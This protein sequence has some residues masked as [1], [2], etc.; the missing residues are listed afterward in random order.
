MIILVD[1]GHGYN[2]NGKASPILD[3]EIPN[4]FVYK[5]RFR[6]ALYNRVIAKEL[7]T[8]LKDND[9]DARLVVP[10]DIDVSLSERVRRINTI[11]NR[12]GASNVILISIHS[13]AAGNGTSFLNANGWEAYTTRGVTKSDKLAE[14]LYKRAEKNFPNRKIRTDCTDGDLDKEADF[15]IIKKSKCP[16]VLTEN[17][18]YDNKEDLKYMTSDLGH[19]EVVR[20]HIYGIIDYSEYLKKKK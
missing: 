6:E 10:E 11:C 12:E 4:Q 5:N 8:K 19:F 14:Y 16:A 18:F 15:Y 17:F 20:T 7:V 9:Y 2:T 1:N 3:F 13:N